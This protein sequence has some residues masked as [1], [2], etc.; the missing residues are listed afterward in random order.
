MTT[1]GWDVDAVLR[2]AAEGAEL[3]ARSPAAERAHWRGLVRILLSLQDD[4]EGRIEFA[5][6]FRAELGDERLLGDLYVSAEELT[7]WANE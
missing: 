2:N 5:R 6:R 4:R 7:G 3:R 1:E